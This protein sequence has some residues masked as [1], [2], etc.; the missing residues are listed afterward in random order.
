MLLKH[1][2]L[3]GY[4]TFANDTQFLFHRG[5]TAVVGP[6]GSG[7]SNVADAIRW[8]LGEQA[9]SDLRVKKT[10]DLIF[11]G[12]ATRPRSG[13]AEVHITL[14][15]LGALAVESDT[16]SAENQTPATN[17]PVAAILAANPSEVTI[18]RRAYRDGDNEYFL[19]GQRVRLRDVVE[20]LERWG[21]ARNTYAVVGQGMIDQ[22][23]SLRPEERRALFEE[24]AGIGT[25][26]TKRR[27]ALGKLEET[28]RN[29]LRVNDIL[30]EIAPRL[31]TLARQAD[32]AQNYE[33]VVR[34]L[35]DKLRMHYA[36][37][38]ARAHAILNETSGREEGERRALNAR[39]AQLQEYAAR[40]AHLRRQSQDLRMKL[41]E[42]RR[43]RIQKESTYTQTARD[44]AV[45]AERVRFATQQREDAAEEATR[46]QDS[47]RALNERVAAAERAHTD[48]TRARDALR[49][50]L[51][52]AEQD[53][54]T[55]K[56]FAAQTPTRETWLDHV[57][58]LIRRLANLKTEWASNPERGMQ[59]ALEL[60]DE[61]T[62]L[63]EIESRQTHAVDSIETARA[64]S[65]ELRTALALA[66]R[67]VTAARAL[68]E[69]E[70][71]SIA[72]LQSEI[73]RRTARVAA[74]NQQADALN[75]QKNELQ[76]RADDAARALAHVDESVSPAE[77]GLAASETEQSALEEQE[78]NLRAQWGEFE[79]THNRAVLNMERARA[80][81]ARLEVEIEDDLASGRM[82]APTLENI[83]QE[84]KM[85]GAIMPGMSADHL[86]LN[87]AN[88]EEQN[89]D[90]ARETGIAM[91]PAR[92]AQLRLRSGAE[93]IEL[94][95]VAAIPAEFDKEI[96]RLRNQLKYMGVVNPNAPQ[97]YAELKTR[98]AF[99][100]E[101]ASDARL[102]IESLH[103]A[104]AE[105]D[106]IMR[107][108]FEETFTAVNAEF[109]NY[110]TLLFNGGT[111]RL[112]LTQPEDIM[113][114]GVDIIAK[115]PGKRATHL[116]ALSG[117]ERA[118]TAAALLFAILKV[119]PTPFCVMDEVDAMLDESNVGRFN[120]ALKTLGAA[121]QIIIITHNRRTIENSDTVYGITMG[122]DG[123]SQAIS[124]RL[125]GTE[126]T[127]SNEAMTIVARKTK[128]KRKI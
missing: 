84:K 76:T 101:Q 30:N 73:A 78:A 24:A 51:Q 110:F 74:L 35:D 11:S 65:A 98:H 96:R 62:R 37:Q 83:D 90:A 87:R 92:P 6:N 128:E 122:E 121:T 41:G 8:V 111:A 19:N 12:S 102:A 114:T 28:Q 9:Y 97:E 86:L 23:L 112:E 79:E 72:S 107:R 126:R 45:L 27:N 119:S 10:Q 117:G 123:V 25:Y 20:L 40:L 14:E 89:E 39:R 36:F 77:T 94:P 26:E 93:L 108:K 57:R 17:D 43:E 106:E 88:G 109:G 95:A 103:K 115:P 21:L 55:Q 38:W 116:A 50:R 7:K 71:A 100:T 81:I 49:E 61:A 53:F 47:L 58:A 75:A 113:Q 52:N 48:Q 105:L 34:A 118:L 15:N 67:E 59:A 125:N 56:N 82:L 46:P 22:A 3:H 99:L 1:L 2:S 80:D 31:P 104:I 4:K 127:A 42:G 5:V 124:L 64:H 63:V 85:E 54:T 120:D 70:R 60:S 32:R 66:E 91:D 13:V 33:G 68:S 44:L 29:L 69:S 16:P 18:G